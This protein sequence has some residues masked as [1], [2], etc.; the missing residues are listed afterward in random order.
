MKLLFSLTIFLIF[1]SAEIFAIETHECGDRRVMD[2]TVFTLTI[3]R[4]FHGDNTFQLCERKKPEKSFLILKYNKNI[5]VKKVSDF[6]YKEFYNLYEQALEYDLKDSSLGLD[7]SIWCLE[8]TRGFAYSKVCF[9]SPTYKT[10][11][12]RLTGF[13]ELVNKLWKVK[14]FKLNND[15]LY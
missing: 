14:E 13:V 5:I 3:S 10:E 1:F 9:W 11:K 8:T 7:G 12:R 6:E 2:G 4:S 15:K